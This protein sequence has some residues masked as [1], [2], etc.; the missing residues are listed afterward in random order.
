M[1][2]PLTPNPTRKVEAFTKVPTTIVSR[3]EE[4]AALKE[5]TVQRYACLL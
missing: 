1:V 3:H 2:S 5:M 4:D